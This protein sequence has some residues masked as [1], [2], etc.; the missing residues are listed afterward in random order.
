MFKVRSKAFG[1]DNKKVIFLLS[2]WGNSIKLYWLFSKILKLYGY[3]VITYIYDKEIL[4]SNIDN[5][6]KNF[7][8][9]R[10]TVL[11]KIDELKKKKYT[12][13]YL[14]GTSLGT[15]L[16]LMVANESSDI[17]KIILNMTGADLVET[18]WGW[19][20]KLNPELH[21]GFQ[22]QKIT[23]SELRNHWKQLNPINNIENLRDRKLLVYLA[24]HDDVIPYQQGLQLLTEFKKR[25]YS[26]SLRVSKKLRH[27][28]AAAINLLHWKIYIDFLKE[29]N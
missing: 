15:A 20:D 23:L 12:S 11:Q 27:V 5:T 4:S 21:K 14:F 10:D 7:L 26:Y 28:S 8:V 17:S 24:E 22:K 18:V 1:E 13:F 16:S 6:V 29:R 25:K 9:V 19:G 2:G 3:H